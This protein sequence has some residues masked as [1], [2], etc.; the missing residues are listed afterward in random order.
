MDFEYSD[1]V[2]GASQARLDEFM[3]EGSFPRSTRTRDELGDM[4]REGD[5]WHSPRA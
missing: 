5:P 2:D 1:K 3:R 4:P